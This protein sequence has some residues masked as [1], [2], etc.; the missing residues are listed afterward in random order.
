MR[1][2]FTVD[3]TYK[4]SEIHSKYGGQR[5]GGISTPKGRP[6]L[7]LFSGGGKEYGYHDDWGSEELFYYTGEG[8]VGGM[9]F[10]GGNKA[11]RDHNKDGKDLH[12]FRQVGR[13]QVRYEGPF[14]CTSWEFRQG[15]DK[16]GR[17]RQV[18]I[19][20]LV[21]V[22]MP[23]PPPALPSPS[24]PLNELRKKA[25][26]GAS[27]AQKANAKEGKRSYYKRSEDVRV[28][29]LTRANGVCEVCR[30]PAPFRRKDR[31]P[32]LEPHHT[33]KLSD[34]GPDHPRWVGAVCPNCH[35]E[36]HYGADGEVVDQRLVDYLGTIESEGK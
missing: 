28:Y 11:I 2:L 35:R 24:M 30:K 1:S 13:G 23:T 16:T 8:Q 20:S 15:K 19:F 10:T 26:D 22:E 17:P 32:Y 18:I 34:E 25:Y 7:L 21:R 3:Q 12:L 6:Y 9:Q 36:I 5:Q 4:R 31:S 27:S 29:V 33:R 14:H